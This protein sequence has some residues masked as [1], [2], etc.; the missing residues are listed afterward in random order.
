MSGTRRRVLGVLLVASGA[1]TAVVLFGILPT[2]F[3]AITVAVLLLPLRD[4]FVERGLSPW[5]ASTATTLA[6]FVAVVLALSPLLVVVLLRADEVLTFLQSAPEELT[7]DVLGMTFVVTF[8]QALEAATG[9]VTRLG[10]GAVRSAP[11]FGLK[12]TVF[13]MVV[14][15][16]LLNQ[17][18]AQRALIGVVPAGYRDVAESFAERIHSTLFAVYIMQAATAVGTFL[19]ALPVFFVLGYS[20]PITLAVVAAVLQFIPVV[21]PS[22]LV[23]G[24]AAY[25]LVLG[26]PVDAAVVLVVA[27]V[28]VAWLPD[29]LIRPRLAR[30]T[31]GLSGTLYFVGFIG[32]ILTLGVV[33][34]V[35]GP[36]AIAVLAEAAALLT[37]DLNEISVV[38][39]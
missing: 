12:L 39:D 30:Q 4:A 35:A 6:A 22:V 25:H 31:T 33:G 18:E 7:L 26:Q 15:A 10:R 14:F 8:E 34:I 16:L 21:G 37:D 9:V 28:L 3:F 19:I 32:G 2:V 13:A 1:L 5:W 36:L 27:G 29:V 20:I 24:I 23:L 17:R 38:E 11:V